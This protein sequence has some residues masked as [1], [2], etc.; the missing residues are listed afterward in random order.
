MKPYAVFV[1]RVQLPHFS[2]CSVYEKLANYR[3]SEF[4]KARTVHS[5]APTY[6]TVPTL[7]P[8]QVFPFM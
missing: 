1:T 7:E 6:L 8:V 5:A 2:S 4:K 3:A